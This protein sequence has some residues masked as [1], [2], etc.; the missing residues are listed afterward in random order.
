MRQDKKVRQGRMTFILVRGIGRA[1][2]SRDADLDIVRAVLD[3]ALAAR[4]AR[5][6]RPLS[7]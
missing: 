3:E 6:A 1:F 7:P 2:V 4:T 5:A